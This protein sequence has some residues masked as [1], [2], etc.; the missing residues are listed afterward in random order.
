MATRVKVQEEFFQSIQQHDTDRVKT[1]LSDY[2]ELANAQRT[3]DF[4]LGASTPLLDACSWG[5]CIISFKPTFFG[6]IL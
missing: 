5:K 2:P 6:P 4:H 3:Q 1:I